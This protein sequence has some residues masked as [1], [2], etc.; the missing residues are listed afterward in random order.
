M[1]LK[2][3]DRHCVHSCLV[4]VYILLH[5]SMLFHYRSFIRRLCNPF[6][7]S[8]KRILTKTHVTETQQNDPL[9]MFE[10]TFFD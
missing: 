8:L 1:C 7:I 5:V 9:S 2:H 10:R 6:L 4:Y 3:G